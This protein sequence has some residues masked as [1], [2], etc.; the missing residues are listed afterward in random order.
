MLSATTILFRPS[1]TGALGALQATAN[2][3]LLALLLVAGALILMG[4]SSLLSVILTVVRNVFA[5]IGQ[6]ILGAYAG[7]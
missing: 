6:S 5:D 7:V 3:L 4:L 1:T 2:L